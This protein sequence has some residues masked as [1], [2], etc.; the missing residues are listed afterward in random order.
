MERRPPI[1]RIAREGPRKGPRSSWPIDALEVVCVN[2]H[3]TR[4]VNLLAEQSFQLHSGALVAVVLI[5]PTSLECFV[6]K[7]VNQ[8]VRR[9]SFW[10]YVCMVLVVC[11]R[12]RI[13]SMHVMPNVGEN[14]KGKPWS[15]LNIYPLTDATKSSEAA[16][17][18]RYL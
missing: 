14:S 3:G 12:P 11:G 10:N 15:H 2:L 8:A 18:V 5:F 4:Q 16:G 7:R 6:G 17:L 13:R 1:D 9:T